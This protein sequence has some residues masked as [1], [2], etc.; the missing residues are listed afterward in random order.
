M[1]LRDYLKRF[2]TVKANVVQC[3][4][5]IASLAFKKVLPAEQ[6]VYREKTIAL[7]ETL[8]EFIVKVERYA[9]WNED[10]IATKKASKHS[11]SL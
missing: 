5:R 10:H 9:L 8:A 1:S 3:D 2:K 7:S 6:E 4:D 11:S